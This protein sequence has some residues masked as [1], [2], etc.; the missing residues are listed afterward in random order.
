MNSSKQQI[1]IVILSLWINCC[2]AQAG[3]HQINIGDFSTT[4]GGI[5]KNCKI[6]YQTLGKLNTD[7][8]NVV[9]L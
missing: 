5:I 2:F 3:L 8:S 9:L 4:E 1:L 6:G 7:K